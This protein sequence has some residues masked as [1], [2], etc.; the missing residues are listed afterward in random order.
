MG[1]SVDGVTGGDY[2]VDGRATLDDSVGVGSSGKAK[3]DS[4][5]ELGV[6]D[7]VGSSAPSAVYGLSYYTVYIADELDM[8]PFVVS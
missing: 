2:D 8:V 7:Y 3:G 1:D 4:P 5:S 6:P